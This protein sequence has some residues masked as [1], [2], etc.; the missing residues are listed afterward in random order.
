[1]WHIKINSHKVIKECRPSF[2]LLWHKQ[3]YIL[4][5]LWLKNKSWREQ[6]DTKEME[7]CHKVLQETQRRGSE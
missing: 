4:A 7:R 2:S 3:N 5:I 6:V 1:M